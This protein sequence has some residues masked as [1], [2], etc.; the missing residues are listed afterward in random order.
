MFGAHLGDAQE[1]EDD[2][3]DDDAD[4]EEE[5]EKEV[6]DTQ[7]S[8]K[9]PPATLGVKSKEEKVETVVSEA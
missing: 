3:D 1:E 5:E 6:L 9:T 2:D 4:D 7:I 8:H